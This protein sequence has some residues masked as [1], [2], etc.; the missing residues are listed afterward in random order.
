MKTLR[1]LLPA[2]LIALVCIV[3]LALASAV[4]S[5]P[6]TSVWLNAPGWGRARVVATTQVE[7]SVPIAID[8]AGGIY[9]FV[10]H[11]QGPAFY[12][13]VV[14]LN[15]QAGVAWEHT[16]EQEFAEPH[17]LQLHWNGT[18]L[19]LFWLSDQQLFSARLARDGSE[20]AAPAVLSGTT[21]VASYSA[22]TAP[23]GQLHVWYGG[24]RTAPGVYA[25]A[26]GS[27]ETAATLV[28]PNG[29]QPVIQLDRSGGVHAV[30]SVATPERKTLVM[31]AA[32]PQ[33]SHQL[34]E[35]D[36]P[37][38]SIELEGPWFGLDREY[39]YL[40]WTTE[41]T[42]GMNA[43]STAS[44]YRS[45][46]LS[47]PSQTAPVQKL[48]TPATTALEYQEPAAAQGYTA[49]PRV[50]LTAEQLAGGQS[51]SDLSINA[52]AGS[53]LAV[54]GA[55]S[56]RVRYG[57][58]REQAGIIFFQNGAPTS[59]QLLGYSQRSAFTPALASD[60]AGQLYATWREINGATSN[61]F[62]ASTAPDV[63]QALGNISLDDILRLTTDI[64]FGMLAGVILAP[65]TIIMWIALPLLTLG[66]TWVIRRRDS[67][68]VQWGTLASLG[69]AGVS[70]WVG[71]LVVLG[72]VVRFVPFSAWAPAIPSWMALPLQIGT[73]LL[74]TLLALWCAWY[75]TYRARRQSAAL[76]ILIY[77]A[78]DSLLTM[79]IYGEQLAG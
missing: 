31:Y 17:S 57:D 44:H 50:P 52:G 18:E 24:P 53:E 59:Y 55:V 16:F 54:A 74:I 77:T 62:F 33:A 39:G 65:F 7:Q 13:R 1:G 23:D 48:G 5:S 4:G 71:K 21:G 19:F 36:G 26:P 37:S 9:L 72:Q 46:L 30:W 20:R 15:R 43:G 66:L 42:A 8:E 58:Q 38:A 14:A 78:I 12:P 29:T 75:F 45:F 11:K 32:Y 63:R 76:F 60:Q 56:V 6:P 27:P 34:A 64:L 3:P 70:Y 69:I 67:S 41:Q 40:A 79:A 51:V 35:I 68:L 49:G 25:L 10:V 28:D 47:D 2:L 73:A 61:V 22:A